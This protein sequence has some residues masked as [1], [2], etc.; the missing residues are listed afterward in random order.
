MLEER[1]Q[2]TVISRISNRIVYE[3]LDITFRNEY[4][5]PSPNIIYYIELYEIIL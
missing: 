5:I 1:Y 2:R 4:H 3:Y